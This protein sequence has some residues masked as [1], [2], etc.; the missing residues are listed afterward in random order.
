MMIIKEWVKY[1]PHDFRVVAVI[2]HLKNIGEKISELDTSF[3]NDL[4]NIYSYLSSMNE[5]LLEYEEY[6]KEL[7]NQTTIKAANRIH[8]VNKFRFSIALKMF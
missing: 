3:T 5:N 7:H 4:N 6:L 2:T 8:F 1:F